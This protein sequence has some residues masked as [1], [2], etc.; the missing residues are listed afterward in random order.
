MRIREFNC[1][2]YISINWKWL[3][4]QFQLCIFAENCYSHMDYAIS[5]KI[6]YSWI[7]ENLAWNAN[8]LSGR[9]VELV[10]FLG[11]EQIDTASISRTHLTYRA[12][13]EILR[14]NLYTCNHPSGATRGETALYIKKTLKHHEAPSYTVAQLQVACVT[15]HLH[16]GTFVTIAEVYSPPRHVISTDDYN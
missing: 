6:S 14:F 15:L 12:R 1:Q 8:G 11:T 7:S 9:K 5:N 13:A 10:Q 16:C 2:F 4:N 3:N